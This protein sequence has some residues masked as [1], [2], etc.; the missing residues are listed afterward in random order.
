VS[1]PRR[2]QDERREATRDALLAAAV[3]LL[4]E[5]GVA[6]TTLADVAERAGVSKGA[7]T[8]HFDAK[9]ALLDAALERVGTSLA[10][11]LT[12]IWD[13]MVPPFPRLRRAFAGAVSLVATRPA[14]VR[15]FAA[16]AGEGTRDARLGSIAQRHLSALEA[17]FAQ[18][19]TLTLD[20]LGVRPKLSPEA[21]ARS[22]VSAALGEALRTGPDA[23]LADLRALWE[24]SLLA[25]IE[26]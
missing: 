1:A 26:L 24:R 8:H 20:E 19:L 14:E 5:R 12:A 6:A 23:D 2:T 10:S 25:Q 16:L 11:A 13:P 18:G 9:D 3:A 17:T 4:S 21:L 15:V 7:L 22:L